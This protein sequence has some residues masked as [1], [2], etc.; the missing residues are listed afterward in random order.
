MSACAAEITQDT[1]R[2]QYIDFCRGV[3]AV[4]IIAVHTAFWGGQRYTPPWFHNLTLFLDVPFFYYLS[5]WA[6]SY[7]HADLTKTVKSLGKIWLKW[8]FFTTLLAAFCALSAFLPWQFAGVASIKEL[9]GCYF[10][11]VT[12]PGFPVVGGSIWFIPVYFVVLVGNTIVMMLLQNAAQAQAY[13][14][15]Y[16]Y[17]LAA[18]FLWCYY[19]NYF[20]GLDA[21][22]FLFYSFF[23]MLGQNR[24]G[25][26]KDL[27]RLI[28]CLA[29]VVVGIV[30]CTRLQGLPLHDIQSAKFPPSAKYGFVSMAAILFAKFF[31]GRINPPAS[32]STSDK[33]PSFIS[34]A[35]ASAPL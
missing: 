16:L 11:N 26:V 6:M 25:K 22:R 32:L 27:R 28:L 15:T 19:G 21:S 7:R 30:A 5:G 8:V 31:E 3:A 14:R 34:L 9:V 18:C 23:W 20:L 29:A 10:F 33:M 13:K 17:L 35:R 4:G 24:L 2:N 1:G 12:F